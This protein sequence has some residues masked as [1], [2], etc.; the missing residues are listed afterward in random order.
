MHCPF[1]PLDWLVPIPGRCWVVGDRRVYSEAPTRLAWVT[2]LF[3]RSEI[4]VD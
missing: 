4:E 2:A 1:W 3:D